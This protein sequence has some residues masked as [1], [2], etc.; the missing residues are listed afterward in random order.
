MVHSAG[1]AQWES[2]NIRE[3]FFAHF[4]AAVNSSQASSVIKLWL[5]YNS[6]NCK[7][8]AA[9][10]HTSC[11]QSARL[12]L[13]KSFHNACPCSPRTA[14]W[15]IS[16]DNGNNGDFRTTWSCTTHS[17]QTCQRCRG[18][19]PL[20]ADALQEPTSPNPRQTLSAQRRKNGLGQVPVVKLIQKESLFSWLPRLVLRSPLAGQVPRKSAMSSN[21]AST[22]WGLSCSTPANP[23]NL[24]MLT[25]SSRR[26]LCTASLKCAA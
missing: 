12:Y 1:I 2:S 24:N 20:M 5:M 10:D 18:E 25:L 13:S 6:C 23:S 7:P 9:S 15:T 19:R 22:S 26:N 3:R 11:A 17:R 8:K 4:S 14:P 16:R 21:I